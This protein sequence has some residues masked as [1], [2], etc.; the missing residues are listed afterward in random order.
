MKY[1]VFEHRH[2]FATWAAARASQRGYA[3]SME[4]ISALEGQTDLR[5][6]CQSFYQRPNKFNRISAR[7]F[8]SLHIAWSNSMAGHLK[9]IRGTTYGRM[10]KMIN[11]YLK[12]MVVLVKP[13]S[14]LSKVIHPPI[15]RILL[16]NIAKS[17]EHLKHFDS[18]KWTQL[19]QNDYYDLINQ[20]RQNFSYNYFWEI[21]NFWKISN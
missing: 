7:Q 6:Y 11:I 5:E 17:N 9:S 15:D 20:L 3:T 1:S 10:A 14:D 18:I 4:L 2:R 21:E 13:S 16:C 12:C 8:D 19:N